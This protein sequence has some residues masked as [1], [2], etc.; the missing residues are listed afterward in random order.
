[1]DEFELIRMN[2]CVLYDVVL[3]LCGV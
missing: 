3:M 2:V 1:L